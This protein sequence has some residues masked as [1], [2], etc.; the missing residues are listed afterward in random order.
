MKLL[1]QID[2]VLRFFF[3][4]FSSTLTSVTD[5]HAI[6]FENFK[7][8]EDY[9]F[10]DKNAIREF[11]KLSKQEM[12]QMETDEDHFIRAYGST[13]KEEFFAVSTEH[14]F[15]QPKQFKEEHPEIYHLLTRIYNQDPALL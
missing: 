15:E 2:T 4:R 13:N 10:M 6:Y 12:K 8:N 5:L 1:P 3:A 11:E 9:L 7:A 14:F